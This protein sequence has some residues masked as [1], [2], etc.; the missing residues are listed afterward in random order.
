M[1]GVQTCALPICAV[2][3]DTGKKSDSD[4]FDVLVGLRGEPTAKSTVEANV[5]YRSQDYENYGNDF[6]S[7]VF[8]G[9]LVEIF[10]S[11][12]TLR[13]DFVRTTNGTNYTNNPYYETTFIA[14]NFKHGF[15]DRF[16]GSVGLSYQLNDYP[17]S[18]TEAGKTAT[19]EDDFWTGGVG[20]S[21]EMPTGI[22]VDVKYEHRTR[23]ST[24]S[25]FDYRNNR[26]IFGL[27]IGF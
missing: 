10:T 2:T 4:Y 3:H 11:R 23:D 1:T 20:F 22:T 13:L 14:A 21:Y 19:R 17:T 8:N 16:F 5:G 26:I 27:A 25:T 24:F 18:T 12:D 6:E 7:V 9:N 15:T